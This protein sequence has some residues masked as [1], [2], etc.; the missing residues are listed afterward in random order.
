MSESPASTSPTVELAFIYGEFVDTCEVP[1]SSNVACLRDIVKASL[2][3]SMG[4]QVEV[5]NIRLHNLVQDDGSWPDE[6]DAAYTDGHSVT[7]TDLVS[8]EFPG[9]AVEGFR[10]EIDREHVTQRSVLS[11]EKVDLS[12]ISETE[13]QMIFSGCKRGRYVLGGVELPPELKQRIRDG[14][15]ENVETLGTPWDESDMTKKLFIY[16]ALKSCLRAA[17]KARSDAT[18]LDLV[19]DFEIDCEGLIACGTVDFVITKGERLVMVIETAK[20]GIKRGKHPTLAKL[21]ALR[22][23][24]KQLHKS[25][26]AIMGIC[27]DMSCW[28]FFDRSSGSLKQEIAY[29]EDDL[30]DAMIYICRKLY[31]VLLSL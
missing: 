18:K 22:I 17:N 15:T 24:N 26:H 8:T 5:T 7:Y 1:L 20:G 13:T 19:C 14:C 2:R 27:T 12:E 11:S 6:P 21:E 29:M 4:L 28:M 16:D 10:V 9:A 3:D 25:W 23:K 31:R 30:P